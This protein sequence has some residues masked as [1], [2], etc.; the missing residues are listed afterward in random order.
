MP[1]W[2]L[3]VL[4]SLIWGSTWIVIKFQLGTVPPEASVAY[5]F[6]LSAVILLAW[7]V[8]AK[9]RLR[10]GWRQHLSFMLL[11]ALNFAI[12]YVLVYV[13]EQYLT[14]GLVAVVF[15]LMVFWNLAG[16]RVLF[17]KPVAPRVSAGATLGVVGVGLMF[18]P[19]IARVSLG[20]QAAL[21]LLAAT[22]GTLS[23]SIGNLYAQRLYARDLRVLP[24]TAWS[25]TYGAIAVALY[26]WGAG[27]PFRWEN[28]VAYLVSLAYLTVFGTVIAFVTYLTLL[29]RIGAGRAGY[30]SAAIP[31]IAMLISTLFE[32]Y[33]WTLPALLGMGLVL[34][35][36]V[37]V[38]RR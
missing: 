24:G 3:F 8:L 13:S 10:Y 9:E 16:E 19:E 36:N 26:A 7:C 5:R 1:N 21:G 6:G 2:L 4:P 29:K 33:T 20:G 38:L 35:G 27:V 14:S 23:S 15:V 32:H 28:S 30:T 17:A 22:V 37:L 18:W 25:M 11:G 12:N 31:V 34:A